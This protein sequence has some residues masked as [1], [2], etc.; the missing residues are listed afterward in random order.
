MQ[1]Q[2]GSSKDYVKVIILL[3]NAGANVNVVNKVRKLLYYNYLNNL[4]TALV[5]VRMY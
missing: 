4:N 1:F 3:M 2:V 5:N